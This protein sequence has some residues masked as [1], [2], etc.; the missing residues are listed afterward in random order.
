MTKNHLRCPKCGGPLSWEDLAPETKQLLLED[1]TLVP[2]WCI[3][4]IDA[5]QQDTHRLQLREAVGLLRQFQLLCER[6]PFGVLSALRIK[7]MQLDRVIDQLE[8][9]LK[10]GKNEQ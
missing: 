3:A 2:P 9:H 4:C 10:Q 6:T 1:P 5:S 7:P 8:K